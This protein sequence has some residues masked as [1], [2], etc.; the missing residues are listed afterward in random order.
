MREGGGAV[1]EAGKGMLYTG[2]LTYG[3]TCIAQQQRAK[4]RAK[5]T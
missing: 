2:I 4:Q 5:Q 1:S 3:V